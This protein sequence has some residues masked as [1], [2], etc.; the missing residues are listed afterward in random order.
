ME[1]L[2]DLHGQFS[3]H[4]GPGHTQQQKSGV[5]AYVGTDPTGPVDFMGSAAQPTPVIDPSCRSAAKLHFEYTDQALTNSLSG[6]TIT[7]QN[8]I[9]ND[10]LTFTYD[11]SGNLANVTDRQTGAVTQITLAGQGVVV[12]NTGLGVFLNGQLVAGSPPKLVFMSEGDAAFQ[13]LCTALA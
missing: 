13:A 7:A 11:A 5:S 1:L 9:E 8:N 6:K 2:V 3:G 12:H 4:R 10:E